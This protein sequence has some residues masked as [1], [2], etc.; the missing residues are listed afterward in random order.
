MGPT[1]YAPIEHALKYVVDDAAELESRRVLVFD[2][3]AEIAELVENEN[4]KIL[5]N[6]HPCVRKVLCSGGRGRK[7]T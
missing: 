1:C 3:I 4:N 6:I 7:V 2:I 5:E